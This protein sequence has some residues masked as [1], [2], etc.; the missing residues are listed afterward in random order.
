[1]KLVLLIVTA[2][3]IVPVLVNCVRYTAPAYSWSNAPRHSSGLAPDP[4]VHREAVVQIYHARAFAWRGIFATHP[5]IVVKRTDADVYKRYEVVGWG[6]GSKLRTD[7]AT[8]DG[9][10]YGST[11]AL[12]AD[13]RGPEAEALIDRIESAVAT[14]PYKD[15]YVTWPGPNS[16]TFLAHVARE[17]PELSLD[18]PA[19]AIGKDYRPAVVPAG[20]LRAQ[21]DRCASLAARAA[22]RDD[23]GR[24][25]CGVQPAGPVLRDGCA[26]PGAEAAGDRPAGRAGGCLAGAAVLTGRHR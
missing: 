3:I 21:R 18:I 16:N 17:V 6:N 23:C 9:L 24:G 26:A 2:W 14:Y 1:M 7:Y 20:R 11:P 4:K 12:L 25:R 19:S 13:V 22:G 8:V 10:W 15:D 5:W